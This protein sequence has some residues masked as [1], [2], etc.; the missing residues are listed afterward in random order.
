MFTLY[1]KAFQESIRKE[2]SKDTPEWLLMAVGLHMAYRTLQ[3]SEALGLMFDAENQ[4]D[5][6]MLRWC[7]EAEDRATGR[8]R[9][10]KSENAAN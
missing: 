2:F 9:V 3:Q 6:S 8:T 7:V 4:F 1:L 5:L 10:P